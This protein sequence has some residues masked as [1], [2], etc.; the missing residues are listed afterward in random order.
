V[1]TFFGYKRLVKLEDWQG[2]AGDRNWVP[3]RSAYELA[4]AWHGAQGLPRSI[5]AALDGSGYEEL[6]GVELDLCLIEKPVFLETLSAPSM[7]DLMAYG[8]NAKGNT[9]LLGVEGKA[10]EVLGPRVSAWLRGDSKQTPS[11][12][13]PSRLKRLAF[14]GKLLAHHIDPSSDLRYQLIHRTVS[15]VLE[16]QLH[17]S[18]AAVVMV[19]AFGPLAPDNWHDFEDFLQ[20]L[21]CRDPVAGKVAGPCWLGETASLPIY[22]LWWQQSLNGQPV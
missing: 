12:P 11:S 21:G 7:T 3:S 22:F 1:T 13:R 8:H 4:C 14:L 18:A 16:A 5:R 9:V 17:G 19:H 20:C 2:L 10:D 6:Q 15:V